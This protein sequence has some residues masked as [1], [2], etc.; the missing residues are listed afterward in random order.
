MRL[1]KA[2]STSLSHVI[3]EALAL[4]ERER[5]LEKYN[6]DMARLRADPVASAEYDAEVAAWDATLLDGLDDTPENDAE[7]STDHSHRRS[8]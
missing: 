6:E 4:Y 8:A 7:T 3:D 2:D 1:A 5:M